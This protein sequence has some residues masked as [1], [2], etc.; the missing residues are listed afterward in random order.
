MKPIPV[1]SVTSGVCTP[2]SSQR[3]YPMSALTAWLS[4]TRKSMVRVPGAT[5]KLRTQD[6][7]SSPWAGT[8]FAVV[9]RSEIDVEVV[10]DLLRVGEGNGL[11]VVLDEEVEGIDHLHVGD[12]SDG[13]RKLTGAVG[14]HQP[15]Q[16]VAECILLPVHEMIGRLD[17]QRVRLDRCAAVWRRPQPDDVRM[18]VHQPVEGVG[19]A[20]PSATLIPIGGNPITRAGA[21]QCARVI[22][23]EPVS[24]GT[25]GAA[26]GAGGHRCG[27]GRGRTR[28]GHQNHRPSSAAID[29]VMNDRMISVSNMRPSP[30]VVPTCARMR[31]SLKAIDA[32]VSAN[33]SPPRSPRAAAS[34]CPDDAGVFRPA[35]ISSLKRATSSRL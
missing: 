29:G 18:Y 34:H 24:A 23:Q 11:G 13:D 10:P 14:E 15:G 1:P 22:G 8:L 30:M 5:T 28:C 9:D 33:T 35:W 6:W 3:L 2:G 25:F 21:A 32:M 20:V 16:E 27:T 31:S 19:G 12:Q 17:R 26:P 4:A 7:T